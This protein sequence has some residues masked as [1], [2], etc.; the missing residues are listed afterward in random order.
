MILPVLPFP[1]L[2][3]RPSNNRPFIGLRGILAECNIS[4]KLDWGEKRH[5]ICHITQSHGPELGSFPER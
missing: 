3:R 1:A 4:H 2:L 5:D